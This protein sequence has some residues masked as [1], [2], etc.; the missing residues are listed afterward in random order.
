VA[1]IDPATGKILIHYPWPGNVRELQNA[2]EHAV[3]LGTSDWILPEDLPETVLE[4]IAPADLSSA[5]HAALGETRRDCILRAW[6][7]TGGDH[8]EAARILGMHP[9]SLR[10]LIRH[11]GLRETLAR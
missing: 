3:I 6:Q 7:E 5:Y 2:I 10:R 9:N 8:N 1:G 4:G 11:L